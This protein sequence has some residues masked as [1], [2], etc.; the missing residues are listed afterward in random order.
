MTGVCF[1]MRNLAYAR[2]SLG[3]LLPYSKGLDGV[4]CCFSQFTSPPL[5]LGYELE[6]PEDVPFLSSSHDGS[7]PLKTEDNIFSEDERLTAYTSGGVK[8]PHNS[9]YFKKGEGAPWK[10]EVLLS[11]MFEKHRS[12]GNSR[13]SVAPW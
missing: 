1:M 12:D 8:G 3:N 6:L 2:I 11:K 5:L 4:L 10:V 9:S 13:A 7:F